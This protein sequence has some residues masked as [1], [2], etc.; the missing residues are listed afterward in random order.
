[1]PVSIYGPFSLN[2]VSEVKNTACYGGH[3]PPPD[4]V[5]DASNEKDSHWPGA[6]GI[7]SQ[8]RIV[9]DWDRGAGNSYPVGMERIWGTGYKGI[10]G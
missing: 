6:L 1:M 8:V 7:I 5:V 9:E 3:G 2:S 4:E 10:R